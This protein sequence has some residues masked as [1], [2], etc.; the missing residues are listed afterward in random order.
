MGKKKL[1]N[2]IIEEISRF[3]PPWLT[4]E[5]IEI[6]KKMHGKIDKRNFVVALNACSKGSD[7]K[8]LMVIW[9]EQYENYLNANERKR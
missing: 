2:T 1:G 5:L 9:K 7:L 6:F 3:N 4:T 8:Y